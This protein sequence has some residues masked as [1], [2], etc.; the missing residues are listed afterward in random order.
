MD[1]D[2][3]QRMYI[4]GGDDLRN[5]HDEKSL[6]SEF[7]IDAPTFYFKNLKKKKKNANSN[8]LSDQSTKCTN[9]CNENITNLK[10]SKKETIEQFIDNCNKEFAVES[11]YSINSE[12]YQ[13]LNKDLKSRDN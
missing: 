13:F 3:E 4:E 12:R 11:D 7:L 9:A 10:N 8:I 6:I 5:S 1:D 2:R